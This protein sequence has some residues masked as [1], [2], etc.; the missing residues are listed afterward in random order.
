MVVKLGLVSMCGGE[1]RFNLSLTWV[2][3]VVK[4]DLVSMCGGEAR[5]N[6]ALIT[7]LYVVVKLRLTSS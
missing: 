5:F 4:L 2:C 3:E 7:S 6:S 1:A